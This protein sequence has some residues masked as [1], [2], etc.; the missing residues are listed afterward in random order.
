VDHK[1]RIAVVSPSVDRQH[2]T[3]RCLAEQLERLA[4][5]YEIHLYSSSVRDLNMEGITWHRVPALPGPE[6][7]SYVWFFA[8][9]HYLRWRDRNFRS[10]A[11]SLLYSPGINCADA[12]VISI[13][14]LFG[15]LRRR[16]KQELRLSSNSVPHWPRLIHR[17]FYYRLA[18]MLE[19][20]FYSQT[21]TL[22]ILPS[23]RVTTTIE[24]NFHRTKNCSVIYH[25]CD[26]N[27]FR[28]ETR[29]QLRRSA[30]AA[31]GLRDD[32]IAVLLIGNDWKNKGVGCLIE[33]VALSAQTNSCILA[34]GKDDPAPYRAM[35]ERANLN[36]RV[37]FLPPRPDVEF[38]YAAA[39]IYAGP[40]LEDAF[41]LPPLEAMA[42]G[43]PV[44][45]SRNAGVSE[46]I[47]HG[48]DGFILEDPGDPKELAE[49]LQL[50]AGDSELRDRVGRAAVVTASQYTWDR[51][52]AQ[53]I[54][55]LEGAMH[56]SG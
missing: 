25:G 27:R 8:A 2:G 21:G 22:L 45:T 28:P 34:V 6:L 10:L 54:S 13:H 16:L 14:I 11:P 40:S 46:I 55:V 17:K 18:A 15:E 42:C 44:I 50:I 49:L 38:Y 32:Q 20:H 5:V 26:T 4:A 51:N 48:K 33:A 9:N 52:A 47:S 12:D 43:L 24:R 35:I 39:D 23:N 36:D 1:P 19:R 53:L 3:E 41:S 7:F 37:Q 29:S 30:R 56:R 31:L